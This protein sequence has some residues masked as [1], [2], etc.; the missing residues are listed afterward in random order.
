MQAWRGQASDETVDDSPEIGDLAQEGGGKEDYCSR[1]RRFHVLRVVNEV[2]N[3]G[4]KTPVVAAIAVQV[5]DG[6]GGVAE[7][8]PH[9]RQYVQR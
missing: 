5:G 1:M 9:Y 2:R 8:A 3:K 4:G 6:H 7:P